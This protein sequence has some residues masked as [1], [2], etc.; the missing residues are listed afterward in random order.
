MD[1]ADFKAI[2]GWKQWT[3]K[4]EMVDNTTMKVIIR[5]EFGKESSLESI[6][7]RIIQDV[8]ET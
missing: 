8:Q 6:S 3:S 4:V 7:A 5:P 2:E 1:I